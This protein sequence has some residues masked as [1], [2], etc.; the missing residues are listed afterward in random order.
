MSSERIAA[1]HVVCRER[2]HSECQ[3]HEVV[4][5]VEVRARAEAQRDDMQDASYVIL[6]QLAGQGGVLRVSVVM[7]MAIHYVIMGISCGKWGAWWWAQSVKQWSKINH[8]DFILLWTWLPCIAV[9]R[10]RDN[11]CQ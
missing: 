2:S 7:V 5:A 1:V 8:H 9:T 11:L 3:R 10:Y 6:P 4:I